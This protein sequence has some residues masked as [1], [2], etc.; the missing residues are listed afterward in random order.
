M[1]KLRWVE[2]RDADVLFP[3]IYR[4]P[5]TEM[6]VWDG[7]ESLGELRAGLRERAEQTRAGRLHAF[8]IVRAADD[9]PVG[10]IRIAPEKWNLSGDIGVWIGVQ[11]QGRGYGTEAIRL[12]VERAFG[13]LG[14]HRLEARVFVGNVA[15]RRAS[16]FSSSPKSSWT[17]CAVGVAPFTAQFLRSAAIS[18]AFG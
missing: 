12:L 18:R 13:E 17:R 5:V 11:H 1:I 3:L 14:L 7:P 9:A 8:T 16:S 2:E 4:S 6:L 10:M 15:S